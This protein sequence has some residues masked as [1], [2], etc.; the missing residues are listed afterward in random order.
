MLF[1]LAWLLNKRIKSKSEIALQKIPGLEEKRAKRLVDRLL[2]IFIWWLFIW[3][4]FLIGTPLGLPILMVVIV[5]NLL[6]AWLLI[7]FVS[8]LI[9]GENF[10]LRLLSYLV[11][12]IAVLNIIG[13]YDSVTEMLGNIVFAGGNIALSALDIIRGVLIFSLLFWLSGR[14]HLI[15]KEQIQNKTDFTPSI[16]LLF[17]KT[18]RVLLIMIVVLITLSSL[19]VELS[20]FAFLGGAIGVGFGFGLQKIVS[21][22]VSGIIILLDGSIKPGDVIEIDD[23][24]G[25]IRSQ[26]TRFVSMVTLSGKEYLIP[27]ENFITQQVINWSHSNSRVRL[28]VEIGVAYGSDMRQVEEL[29]L[30]AAEGINRVLERPKAVCL[31]KEFGDNTVDF[32]LRFWI[33]DPE[34][35]VY[36]VRSDVLF[37][38]WDKFAEAG[39]EISFPQRDLHLKSFSSKLVEQIKD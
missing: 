29:V 26:E 16:K 10:I 30:A 4:Y 17:N 18:I 36:N 19:G 39:I 31:M 32:E 34:L 27:N 28:D 11:W 20:T 5:G 35:G 24:F 21:N 2:V 37:A 14:L 7:K 9:P 8:I 6:S 15:L 13:L 38:V 22:Y 23:V 1:I 12:T 33:N 25:R 3:G